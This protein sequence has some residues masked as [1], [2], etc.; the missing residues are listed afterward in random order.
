MNWHTQ[1]LW[2]EAMHD[3]HFVLWRSHLDAG[4]LRPVGWWGVS[5]LHWP[6]CHFASLSFCIFVSL[7]FCLWYILCRTLNFP[8]QLANGVCVNCICIFA[9]LPLC[10]FVFFSFC[11]CVFSSLYLGKHWI[12]QTSW[13]M[14]CEWIALER[15]MAVV[16]CTGLTGLNTNTTTPKIPALSQIL[17]TAYHVA[18][19]ACR[20]SHSIWHVLS[21]TSWT[22]ISTNP[23]LIRQNILGFLLHWMEGNGKDCYLFASNQCQFGRILY[24]GTMWVSGRN[25][26][27]FTQI[28]FQ[29]ARLQRWEGRVALMFSNTDGINNG[30]FWMVY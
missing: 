3:S 11:L 18:S 23:M 8:D 1:V 21:C 5:E 25:C 4:F 20:M 13:L 22:G 7:S 17:H 26:E 12:S 2:G 15:V 24:A 30:R 27:R 19:I 28:L 6:F 29:S 9:I 16:S 10:H 14:G